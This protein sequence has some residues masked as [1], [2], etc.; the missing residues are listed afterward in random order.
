MNH[1]LVL[2]TEFETTLNTAYQNVDIHNKWLEIGVN[3][4]QD[5]MDK[6]ISQLNEANPKLCISDWRAESKNTIKEKVG[7][8]GNPSVYA[9]Y[10]EK[11]NGNVDGLFFYIPPSLNSG[12]D[13][14]T[15]QVIPTLIGIYEGI[16]QDM[17]DMHFNNRP[18]YI[19]N[20][21][22]TN[23]SEQRAVKISFLCSELLGF[24]YLDVFSRNYQDVVNTVETQGCINELNT[25]NQ[26]FTANGTNELFFIDNENKKLNLLSNRVT[27]STNP[28]AEMYRYCLKV[29]PAIYMAFNE[30]Y[31]INMDEF[32]N[33]QI[34]MVDVIKNYIAKLQ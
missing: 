11:E 25:F 2:P 31:K 4:V 19:M 30:G 20:I 32:N 33:V 12:N 28:S 17:V 9:G 6:I 16:A 5:M 1:I 8:R 7:N 10:F 14:L 18:V 13:F 29:L 24:K 3:T 26:I 15:R 21:N 34:N 23:R 22:E 27:S